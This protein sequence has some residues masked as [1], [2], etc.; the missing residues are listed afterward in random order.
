M[1]RVIKTDYTVQ[2]KL[3]FE[4][5]RVYFETHVGAT[6]KSASQH[7]KMSDVTILNYLKRNGYS[8][9]KK[10]YVQGKRRRKTA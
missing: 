4:D 8:Y 5:I 2:L 6:V 1:E 10:T 3:K 9:K 7:F